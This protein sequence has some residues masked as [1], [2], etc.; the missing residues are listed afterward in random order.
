MR[1]RLTIKRLEAIIEALTARLAG[2]ID[3]GQD[4]G[5]PSA[6]DYEKALEWAMQK[7]TDADPRAAHFDTGYR[8]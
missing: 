5:S 6:D 2:E 3:V 1:V 8:R 7:R 4:D